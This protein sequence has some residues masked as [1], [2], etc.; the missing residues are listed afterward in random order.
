VAGQGEARAGLRQ[1]RAELGQ[2]RAMAWL[3][4]G[5]SVLV[6]GRASERQG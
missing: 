3:E 4:Q 1:G 2:G 5:R 6:Q